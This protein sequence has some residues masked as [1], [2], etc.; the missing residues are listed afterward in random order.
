ML[1][2]V[3]EALPVFLT[4]TT[5]AGLVPPTGSE[6]NVR[7]EGVRVR[8]PREDATPLPVTVIC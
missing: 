1:D 2:N 6:E 3:S 4:K 5:W 7:L 8:A